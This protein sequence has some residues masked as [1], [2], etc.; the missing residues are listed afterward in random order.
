MAN[1]LFT[2]QFVSGVAVMG[3]SFPSGTGNL[4]AVD[5]P[6]T[7]ALTGIVLVQGALAITDGPDVA[8]FIGS[9]VIQGSLAFTEPPDTI[10]IAGGPILQG[11]LAAT[12]TP[13]AVA[14]QGVVITDTY[15]AVVDTMDTSA[16]VGKVL[17]QGDL[18]FEDMADISAILGKI[19]VQGDL[20]FEDNVDTAYFNGMKDPALSLLDY[21]SYDEIRAILALTDEELADGVLALPIF[22]TELVEDLYAVDPGINDLY[23]Q[24]STTFSNPPE[25]RRF[26]RLVRAYSAYVVSMQLTES[27]PLLAVQSE[28]DARAAYKKFDNPFD[29]ITMM[30]GANYLKTQQYMVDAYNAVTSTPVAQPV[31]TWTMVGSIGIAV[32]PVT[33]T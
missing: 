31:T 11:T 28:N 21:T 25:I 8:A 1:A 16:M 30:V 29:D 12:D 7:V 13:D 19:L 33:N 23:L 9:S 32:D 15:L 20:S 2:P 3:F 22:V 18:S 17:V 14:I 4:V 24:Y 6:D 27:L 26:V 10:S 5:T